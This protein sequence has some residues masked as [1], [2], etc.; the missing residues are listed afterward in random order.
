MTEWLADLLKR[1]YKEEKEIHLT[2][3]LLPLAA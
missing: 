2:I 3:P 1:K